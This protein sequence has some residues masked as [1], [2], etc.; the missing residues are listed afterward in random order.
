MK[1]KRLDLIL[2]VLEIMVGEL[3]LNIKILLEK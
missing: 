1:T 3:N 2:F